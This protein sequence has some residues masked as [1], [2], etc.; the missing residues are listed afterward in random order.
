[1]FTLANRRDL[2]AQ[3]MTTPR[4][5]REPIERALEGTLL[6]AGPGA[7]VMPLLPSFLPPERG[8]NPA[9]TKVPLDQMPFEDLVQSGFF[10][11]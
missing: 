1:M 4:E 6:L 11:T 3:L 2:L 7:I 10:R 8:N 5:H 9:L